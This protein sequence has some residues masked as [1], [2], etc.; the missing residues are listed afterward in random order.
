MNNENRWSRVNSSN[1]WTTD[2]GEDIKV[3]KLTTVH[4]LNIV[5]CWNDRGQTKFKKG[6]NGG[7]KRWLTILYKELL[8][9]L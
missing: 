3:K 4:I 5:E 8:N 9:R 1:V 2:K 7:K 6:H